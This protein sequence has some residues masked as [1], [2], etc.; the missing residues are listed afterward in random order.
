[1]FFRRAD[2]LAVGGCDPTLL[3]MEEADLCIRFH[4]LGRTRLVNLTV[5]RARRGGTGSKYVTCRAGCGGPFRSSSF[6]QGAMRKVL[7]TMRTN[8]LAYPRIAWR[9]AVNSGEGNE[10][11]ADRRV[12]KSRPDSRTHVA[13]PR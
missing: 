5:L 13:G 8:G 11:A 10:G 6:G 4:R 12:G 3:V 2:F 1:M 7:Y 9:K